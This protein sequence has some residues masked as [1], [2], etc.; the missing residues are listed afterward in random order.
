MMLIGAS[1]ISK[2]TGAC[3]QQH[4]KRTHSYVHEL[5]AC[6][7]ESLENTK[8]LPKDWSFPGQIILIFKSL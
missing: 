1:P 4:N 3:L 5:G 8:H 2:N 6:Q 7:F